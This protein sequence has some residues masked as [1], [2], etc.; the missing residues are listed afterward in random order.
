MGYEVYIERRNDWEDLDEMSN[1][2]LEEW[3][4]YVETDPELELT[5]GY[6][7]VIFKEWRAVPGF[8][9]WK[10]KKDSSQ[11]DQ[12]W[13]DYGFGSISAKYPDPDTIRKLVAIAG[14]LNAR[15]RG[16]DGEFYD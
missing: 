16:D 8:C 5:N 12:P 10:Q 13:L 7:D 3:L 4:R 1:I 9:R 14:V 11:E 6:Q 2:T 15:V